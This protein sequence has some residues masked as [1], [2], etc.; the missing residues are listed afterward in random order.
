MK[1]ILA[2]AGAVGAHLAK[3]LSNVNHDI[4]VL[5]TDPERLK[6]VGSTLDVLTWKVVPP[7][8]DFLRKPR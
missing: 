4:T 2:G 6:F 1:I 8:S 3:M 7:P 5:D